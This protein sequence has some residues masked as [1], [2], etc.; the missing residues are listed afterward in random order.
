MQG[1]RTRRPRVSRRLRGPRSRSTRFKFINFNSGCTKKASP[2]IKLKKTVKLFVNVAV[3]LDVDLSV[4]SIGDA[5]DAAV[6]Q[7]NEVGAGRHG[8]V[9]TLVLK[10]KHLS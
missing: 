7:E 5:L 6:G 10:V 1:S 4:D 9:A 2:F 3:K 8:P